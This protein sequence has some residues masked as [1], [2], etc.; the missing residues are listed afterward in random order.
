MAGPYKASADHFAEVVRKANQD[1]QA[2]KNAE[3]KTSME[4]LIADPS[5]LTEDLLTRDLPE[6]DPAT[7]AEFLAG[8]EADLD[9]HYGPKKA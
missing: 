8:V 5:W 7:E 1:E 9:E 6:I 2:A 3:A 4:R